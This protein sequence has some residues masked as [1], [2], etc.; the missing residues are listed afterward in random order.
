MGLAAAQRLCA[1]TLPELLTLPGVLC[2]LKAVAIVLFKP[3]WAESLT[4]VYPRSILRSVPRGTLLPFW[5]IWSGL[6]GKESCKHAP[7]NLNP[8]MKA[9]AAP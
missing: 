2:R 1:N 5:N 7:V 8:G 3:L 9:R 4:F 6:C